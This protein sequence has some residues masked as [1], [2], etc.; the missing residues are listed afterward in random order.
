MMCARIENKETSWCFGIHW[1]SVACRHMTCRQRK[2]SGSVACFGCKSPPA[3]G[4]ALQKS[5]TWGHRPRRDLI[6]SF[7]E[8]PAIPTHNH[9][10]LIITSL[11]TTTIVSLLLVFS[12][13]HLSTTNAAASRRKP[14]RR[15][16]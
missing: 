10:S 6:T 12:S 7:E 13:P 5:S 1:Q 14:A 16:A 8:H 15:P 3:A 9:Q 2:P 4:A 11:T